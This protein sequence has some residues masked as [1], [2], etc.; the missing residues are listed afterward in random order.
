MVDAAREPGRHF[1]HGILAIDGDEIGK[2]SKQRGIGEHLGLMPSCNA[3]SQASRMYLNAACFSAVFAELREF[4]FAECKS[5]R[6]L[7]AV[8]TGTITCLAASKADRVN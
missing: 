6:P 3:S 1:G 8:E 7:Q 4:R 5:N 2:R